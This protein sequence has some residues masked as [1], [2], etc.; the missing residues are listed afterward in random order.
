M[1]KPTWLSH[2][3]WL[4]PYGL[5]GRGFA[6]ELL[7]KPSQKGFAIQA[8]ASTYMGSLLLRSLTCILAV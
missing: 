7:S 3:N 8:G 1:A 5:E 4:N 2:I 6:R